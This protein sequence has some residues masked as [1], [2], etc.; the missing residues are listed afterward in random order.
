MFSFSLQI[1]LLL[2]IV[3][4]D[5]YVCGDNECVFVGSNVC[6]T[7]EETFEETFPLRKG[8]GPELDRN[9]PQ[10]LLCL[11]AWPVGRG[12][13]RGCGLVGVGV[14]CWRKC[15]IVEAGFEVIYA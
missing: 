8:A 13:I 1:A 2:C 11:S 15:V 4:V 9:S 7:F 10:R 12:S 14:A 5:A 6:E 3:L